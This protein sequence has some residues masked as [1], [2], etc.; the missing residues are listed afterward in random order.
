MVHSFGY[1]QFHD[2]DTAVKAC[3]E[4]NNT[5]F[6]GRRLNV[7]FLARPQNNRMQPNPPSKTLFIGNMNY[8][9]TDD[10]ITDLFKGIKNC[11]DVRVA[12]DRY[13]HIPVLYIVELLIC[14][15]SDL[16]A[17]E[18]ANHEVSLMP[19]LLMLNPL[20][21]QRRSLAGGFSLAAPSE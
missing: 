3:E 8:E 4:L 11:L 16:M 5:V 9:M 7:Q 6:G 17:G 20:S 10:D 2:L 12:M 1:V 15:D 21:L 14:S 13:I 18:L 19:I